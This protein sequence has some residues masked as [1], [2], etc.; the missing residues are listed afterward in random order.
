MLGRFVFFRDGR[1]S[2]FV[3]A[4]PPPLTHMR[5]HW[6]VTFVVV[7][8]LS[9][10]TPKALTVVA[11]TAEPTLVSMRGPTMGTSYS[12]KCWRESGAVDEKEL[13]AV[14]N[15]S[16]DT[17]NQQMSTYLADSEL[18]RFNAS[19]SED[20]IVVSTET[21]YVVERAIH[22]NRI[23]DGALDVTVGPLV[24]LWNFGPGK[25]RL[26]K[27]PSG[28]KIAKALLGTGCEH[29][30]VRL[31]PPAIRK[32]VGSLEIDLSSIAKGYAVDVVTE[33]LASRGFQHSMVEIGGE[34]RATGTRFDKKPWRI[35]IETP[36]TRK[37]PLYKVVPLKGLAMATSGDYR[38]FRQSDGRKYC[39][40]IDPRTGQPLVYRGCSVTVLAKTCLEADALATALLVMGD[41]AGYDWCVEQN[42]AALFLVRGEEGIS[43]QA[44]PRFDEFAPN[45][46]AEA[47]R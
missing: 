28:G 22:F 36:A 4:W 25:K 29:V 12:V 24:K 9:G 6:A 10:C 34:V 35:G 47:K 13:H 11:T 31:E 46:A 26:A 27:P 8:L 37:S 18:S 7:A 3:V 33:L 16:L 38:N 40:I 14:I 45:K 15:K 30:E 5:V 32:S 39:H 44:T 1:L 42:V 23:T 41:E 17:V 2:P 21:A 19:T 43:E 20:W